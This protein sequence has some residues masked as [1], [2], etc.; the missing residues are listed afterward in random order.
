MVYRDV[1]EGKF[2]ET[3]RAEQLRLIR[4][5]YKFYVKN[6]VRDALAFGAVALIDRYLRVAKLPKEED[7]MFVAALYL[8]SRH[9]FSF[10][11]HTSKQEFAEQFGI[12]ASSLEWYSENL[13]EKLGFIRI[14][15][16]RHFPYYIDPE[17]VI[18][19]VILSVVRL[20]VEELM[21]R[22]VLGVEVFD[23]DEAIDGIVDRLVDRLKIVPSVF[24]PEI[25]RLVS[26]YMS[27]EIKKYIRS[28]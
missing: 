22:T 24:K 3:H 21:I 26:E 2:Y 5:A 8:I 15:D 1:L 27:K 18:N 10:A 4:E 17:G 14:Y 16:Y 12:K 23:E 13:A 6:D 7:A 19:S 9:P 11:N 28:L 20:T 25:R